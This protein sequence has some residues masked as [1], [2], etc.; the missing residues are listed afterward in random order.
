MRFKTIAAGLMLAMSMNVSAQ[1]M[2][3]LNKI[4]EMG[5][6]ENHTWDYLST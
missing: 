4:A 3:A 6:N 2:K 1:D 5:V